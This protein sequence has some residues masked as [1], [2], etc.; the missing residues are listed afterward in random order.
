MTVMILVLGLV[1]VQQGAPSPQEQAKTDEVS[2]LETGSSVICGYV[3]DNATGEPLVYVSVE[4]TWEDA[5]GTY[6]YNYTH[7]DSAGF[8]LFDTGATN[9][10]LRFS[11]DEYFTESSPWSY[12]DEDEVFW[13]NISMIPVPPQTAH[14]IGFITD[15]ITGEPLQSAYVSLSWRDNQDHYWNNYTYADSEGYY[16]LGSIPGLTRINVY[17]SDYYSYYSDDIITENNSLIWLNVSLLPYPPVTAFLC[18]Y[19]TDDQ[20]GDP[21]QDSSVSVYVTTDQGTFHNFTYTNPLGFYQVGVVPGV[22]DV[23]VYRYDYESTYVHNIMIQDGETIWVN[24]SLT[25]IIEETAQVQGYVVDNET[26]AVVKNAYVRFD[27]RDNLGHFCSKYTFTD[28][29]GYYLIPVPKGDVEF[30]F[31]G[32]GYGITE[33]PW[34]GIDENAVRWVNASIS[35][36]ITL[37]F[38]RPQPGLYIRDIPRF[39]QL[40]RV[41][42]RFFH[43][44]KVWAFGSLECVVNV[45]NASM[46]CNRVDFYVNGKLKTS[47]WMAPYSFVWKGFGHVLPSTVQA[48][49]YDNAGPYSSTSIKV[50]RFL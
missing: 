29:K 32:N 34:F 17:N 43:G 41:F 36:R 9:F 30:L 16:D 4:L 26:S 8:Y 35:P 23:S 40:T 45:T 7:T 14:F 18:G 47:D 25:F 12:I 50:W 42:V 22:V 3:D 28:Q 1:P 2:S 38:S 31:T 33:V 46:G 27:W 37:T 5:Q 48:V 21:L 20:S 11:L 15:N 13:Y 19:I 24:L 39:P 49:A 10:D 44:S 6:H